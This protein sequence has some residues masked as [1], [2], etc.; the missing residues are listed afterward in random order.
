MRLAS[1]YKH[2]LSRESGE[3]REA[4]EGTEM[5]FVAF[6][7]FHFFKVLFSRKSGSRPTSWQLIAHESLNLVW[8]NSLKDE[9]DMKDE[10]T[11]PE[12]ELQ[13]QY[14]SLEKKL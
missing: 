1:T 7:F 3:G 14:C 2:P 13:Q 4:T 9:L 5:F 6:V 11:K 12:N 8:L 10:T